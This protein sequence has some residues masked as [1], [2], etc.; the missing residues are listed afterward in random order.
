MPGLT[1]LFADAAGSRRLWAGDSADWTAV[2]KPYRI[3]GS[4]YYVGSRDLSQFFAHL[5]RRTH[6]DQQQPDQFQSRRFAPVWRSWA[7]AFMTFASCSSAMPILIS[8]AGSA[9]LIR[10][11]GA[12]YMVMDADVSDVESGGRT[13]FQFGRQK[14]MLYPPSKVDRVLHN[15]DQVRLG[16]HVLTAHQT[17][18][19][20]Q[21]LHYVELPDRRP[22]R[23]RTRQ[24]SGSG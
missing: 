21:G 7:S 11:T 23:F 3:A 4:L 2:L 13:N 15:G 17:P 22:R 16:R 19:P 12:K 9:E 8:C 6:P 20:H 1:A 5:A 24:V 18:G 10:L 14:A